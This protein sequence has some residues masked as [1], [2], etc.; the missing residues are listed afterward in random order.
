MNFKIVIAE[1]CV[2]S[3]GDSFLQ[4]CIYIFHRFEF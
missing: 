4:N 2:Y 1:V 3:N